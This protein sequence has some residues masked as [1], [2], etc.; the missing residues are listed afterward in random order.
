MSDSDWRPNLKKRLA[1]WSRYNQDLN[2]VSD[3]GYTRG[4]MEKHRIGYESISGTPRGRESMR[5]DNGHEHHWHC[6]DTGDSTLCDDE[7]TQG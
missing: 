4:S 7:M 3:I 1:T 6:D 5:P 2:T